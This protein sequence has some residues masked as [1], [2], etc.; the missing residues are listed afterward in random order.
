[1]GDGDSLTPCQARDPSGAS[2]Y[3]DGEVG[4]RGE[5][6]EVGVVMQ[7]RRSVVL[8]D[9]GD[10]V[11]ERRNAEV[12]VSGAQLLLQIG[13]AA[14]GALRGPEQRQ[15]RRVDGGE[16]ATGSCFEQQRTAGGDD[17]SRE[18]ERRPAIVA[19]DDEPA[20]LAAVA[21]DLRHA[22]AERYR[23]LRAPSGEEALDIPPQLRPGRPAALVLI[24]A[25]CL[26]DIWRNRSRAAEGV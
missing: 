17:A 10:E 15:L 14:L 16:V 23:I 9:R 19:V 4:V 2:A 7:D 8:G 25:M 3:R 22:F 24:D 6:L 1:V 21:R 26:R 20:V 18:R 13:G 11:V 12:L 5:A